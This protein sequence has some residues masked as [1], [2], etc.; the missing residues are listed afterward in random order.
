MLFVDIVLGSAFF[1]GCFLSAMFLVGMMRDNNR[2]ALVPGILAFIFAV[3]P[4]CALM[5]Y[6]TGFLEGEIPLWGLLFAV[7]VAGMI[8]FSIT[9]IVLK[10]MERGDERR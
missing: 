6:S 7:P 5:Y 10:R 4:G 8:V 2:K 1:L 3:I 9:R